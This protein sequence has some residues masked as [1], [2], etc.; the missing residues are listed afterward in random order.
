M[1]TDTKILQTLSAL[2]VSTTILIT[3]LFQPNSLKAE[4]SVDFINN[5]G[6]RLFYFAERPQQL[7]VY[8]NAGEYINFG[9]SHVGISGGFINVYRPDGTLHSTYNNTGTTAGQAIINDNIEE[10]NGP[11]GGGS[12]Q[13]FGYE[14]GIVEVDPGEEGVWTITLEY[15]FYQFTGFDNLLN[16]EAWTREEDQPDNRRVVLSWDITISQNAAAN[17]GGNMLTGRVFTN[18]YQSIV[19]GN[20][21][22][23]SPTYFL[24]T[25]EGLQFQIDYNDVDPWGFQI[26][27]N[28]KG[29]TTGDLDPT[30]ASFELDEVL[31]SADVSSFNNEQFYLY[32]PQARDLE[33]ITNNKVFFNLPDPNMPATAMVTDIA[34]NDT[35]ITWLYTEAP[36][37]EIEV[38]DVS[39]LANDPVNGEGLSDVLDR[40]NGALITYRTNLGGNV[41]L[42]IDIDNDGIY[43]N[44]NDRIINE[45]AIDGQNQILWD[46]L[47]QNGLALPQQFNRELSYRL[48]VNA[49]ELHLTLSDIE[50]DNGG[51]TLTRLNGNAPNDQFLYDH[52]R[53]GEAVSGNG[54]TPELT[55]E[56]FTFS[57][58]FGD[59]KILDYWT[60]VASVSTI[61]SLLLDVVD[62]VSI[63]P[64]DS[65][66]D[67]IRDDNDID[68]DNDGILDQFEICA[69]L[70]GGQCFPVGLNP[71]FDEDFDGVPNYLDA[72][73]P[74]FDLGCID[75]NA[76]GICDQILFAFDI[77]QDGVPNHLDLDADND[78]I[79]DILE[80]NHNFQD[81]DGNGTIDAAG[82][83]FGLNGL[84]NPLG[85]DDDD[86]TAD[87]NYEINDADNDT[88]PDVYDLD[89][90]NDGI[91]DVAEANFGSFDTDE[92]GML[93]EGENGITVNAN[94]L[95]SLVDLNVNGNQIILPLDNDADQIFNFRDRD[96]DNDGLT[97]AI[98]GRNLDG[99]ADGIIG[100]GIITVNDLGVPISGLGA[101]FT[102]RSIIA[103][104]DGDAIEDYRDLDSDNDGIFDVAEALLTDSDNDGFLFAGASSVDE[105][106]MQI[107]PGTNSANY[108][109]FAPDGDGDSVANYLD[110]DSDNDGIHDVTEA[111][112]ED[113]EGD[114][115]IGLISTVDV[116]GLG[117]VINV[118]NTMTSSFPANNDADNFPDY[119]DLDADNDGINDVVE[120][121]N[122]DQDNDG[123]IDF[124]VNEFGQFVNAG[125]ILTTSFPKDNDND[126]VP[127]FHDLDSD[128]DGLNDVLE[129]G[130]Q[131]PDN[132]GIV[133]T[134]N[135]ATNSD[136]QVVGQN[137]TIDTTSFPLDTDNDGIFDYEDLDADND[138]IFDANEANLSDE[139][140]DGILGV[141]QVEVDENG[142][143]ILTSGNGNTSNPVDT[144]GDGI[145]DFRDIDS[146][147]DQI[148][149]ETECPTGAPCPDFDQS[150]IADFIEFNSITCPIPLVTPTVAHD[151]NICSTDMLS[152]TVNEANI[153]EAAYPGV[154]I[155]YI[156]TNA[157]GI[158]I[159][160]TNNPNYNINGDDPL[161]ILPIMVRVMIDAD[162]E[163]S[164]SN[165]IEVNITPT[166]EAIAT[167]EFDNICVGG[168]VQLLAQEV[169]GASYQWFFN[170]FPF[171]TNQNPILN[172]LNQ[173]TNFGLEVTLN[174]CTSDMGNVF[175]V[176]DEPA[177]IEAQIGTGEYCTGEDVIFTAINNNTDL[178]GN[179]TYTLTGPDGLM[180]EVIAPANGTFEYTLPSVDF[181]NE[182]VYSIIV[183]NGSGCTSNVET[184]DVAIMEGVEQPDIIV[185]DVSVCSG[186]DIMMSTQ[187]FTGPNVM[188]VWSLN[189]QPLDTTTTPNFM[190][191]NAT[192]LDEG[193]YQVQVSS[194]I[195]GT[196]TSAPVAVSLT[197]TSILPEIE[198]NLSGNTACTGQTVNLRVNNPTPET[199]YTWYDPSGSLIATDVLDIDIINIQ[200]ANQGT[201]TVEAN[202]NG[203]AIRTSE[204]ELSVSEGLT[205]PDFDIN[206]L[207]SCAGQDVSIAINNFTNSANTTYTWFTSNDVFF[208]QTTTPVLIFPDANTSI[209]GGYYVVAEQGGCTSSASEIFNVNLVEPPSEMA[210]AGQDTGFC[211]STV[212]NLSATNPTQGTGMWIGT[213]GT[214]V[215]PSNPNTQVDN[216]PLGDNIFTWAL[217]TNECTNYSMD[218]V[219]ISVGDVPNETA[220]IFNTESSFCFSDASDLILT[221]D[222][223]VQSNGQWVM[224]SGPSNVTFTDENLSFTSVSGLVPGTYEVMWQLNTASCGVFS[225][226]NYA[227]TIDELPSDIANAGPDQSFCQGAEVTTFAVAPSVG[228]GAWSSNTGA[229]FSNINDPNATVSGLALGVNVLT[230]TLS[231]G[232]C[233]AYDVDEVV[234]EVSISPN[235]E[236]SVTNN[237]IQICEGDVLNLEAVTPN[238]SNGTWT[239]ISGPQTNIVNPNASITNINYN[240]PGT[241][242]FAWQLS[243]LDCGTFSS[244]NVEVIIDAIPNELANAGVDQTTCGTTIS[245]FAEEVQ[246][247]QGFWTS[248]AGNIL[249]PTNPF[250]VVENLV[251]GTH[252]FTWTLSNGVCE[253]FS[254]DQ[255]LI[256]IDNVPNETAQ[257]VDAVI[258]VCSDNNGGIV[259]LNAISPTLST[260][261]WTQIDGPSTV[262]ILDATNENASATGF[263]MGQYNFA[264]TLSSGFCINFSSA[265]LTINVDEVPTGQIANAGADQNI[266]SSSTTNLSASMPTVGSG[267]WTIFNTNGASVV[268]VTDP[269]S[270][271]ILVEGENIFVWS[272]SNGGCQNYQQDTVSVF[273]SLPEDE[274]VV[275]TEDINICETDI[276]SITLNASQV[277]TATGVWTQSTGPTTVTINNPTSTEA[278]LTDLSPGT[279]TFQWTLSDG[280]CENYDS[281]QITVVIS[282][283][284]EEMA[285]IA[286]DEIEICG[287][288]QTTLTAGTP[289]ESTGAWSTN[290]SGTISSINSESTLVSNLQDGANVFTWTLSSGNCVDFSTASITVFV[291]EGVSAVSDTYS[292]EG[293]NT[294]TSENVLDNEIFNGNTDWTLALV[295]D[296]PEVTL[297]NDGSFTFIPVSGFSGIYTFEYEICDQSC[298]VCERAIV[299]ID[300]TPEPVLECNVPNVLTPN[301]DNKNDALI[302]DCANQFE[303]NIIQIFNRWGDKVHEK[304]T[305]QNDWRGTFEGDD[306]PAG[307]YFY[308]FKKDQDD[309]EAITGYITIIR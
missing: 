305:Y 139:D 62:D 86:L 188:Y 300:V 99:D 112:N 78:G 230:W 61:S 249:D 267:R 115:V 151:N 59:L 124:T 291:E 193:N 298:G 164:P 161:L 236:A 275:V 222:N 106:G 34:R 243:T 299:N 26:N 160:T 7:K 285:N 278:N 46:G 308:I 16:N 20:G 192:T 57:N 31:R 21:V 39:L 123:Q 269:N 162:C 142:R 217:S 19:N 27:S 88:H 68:N 266:C 66:G 47:D 9:A 224:V 263:I 253:N 163:S 119:L 282:S 129:G 283:I 144:D 294:L 252:T 117:V 72:D 73:D 4:G 235:E 215:D 289:I 40:S 303:N 179:I 98:E 270:E 239:Q 307:T 213:N 296:S 65:D 2:I 89:S 107:A 120:G 14:P 50:N 293:G 264:W 229:S 114:G 134:G 3:L 173:S 132:D 256:T 248:T 104:H 149:D 76:D 304:V 43:G 11:T 110:R 273:L 152:L 238:N 170:S 148:N 140:Y 145:P 204:E 81:T 23:T 174:G 49:G 1:N 221:A 240:T 56:P 199:V 186:D 265:N 177:I 211:E 166:P 33:D 232:A 247:G 67:G 172:A 242:N 94:G 279:Y 157:D 69:N 30:Y 214:I 233:Q 169:P 176:A 212:V 244:A 250:T 5:N 272:L 209:N 70:E 118:P 292:V 63:I 246:T 125:Q 237:S 105:F 101:P 92:N 97:D 182:G 146:D 42:I 196:S 175:I 17:D 130:S 185:S 113:P 184:F 274:A 271:V 150:G 286:Q 108:I 48:V 190:V 102:V 55:S 195:C 227:F 29:I 226:D 77:D 288:N 90:D 194:G 262:N 82:T 135:P 109:P 254:N 79:T 36:E 95:I 18:E 171:S 287:T 210:S 197:D 216:L 136:G 218:T 80:A 41:Q 103:D 22:T 28:N 116:N 37:F 6:Y 306:L 158:D 54:T 259:N 167:S 284:P 147:N 138:G 131:D 258:D 178:Q 93:V 276:S 128:N 38:L 200:L 191:A 203:C 45:T 183:D 64:N 290:G 91:Y 8:A 12:T 15:G 75:Q 44:N 281:D 143:V 245:L 181:V 260:G 255:V 154:D 205:M 189:G 74:A 207:T 100:E 133:G 223:P 87:V 180:V 32:E 165:P 251:P 52:S 280:L 168:T 198:S 153:Y 58:N 141:G 268:D 25:N 159:M 137:G 220:T 208:A 201:Y 111:G 13:G 85:T 35:H 234:I 295:S 121:G 60:Y 297:N 231:N 96:S 309:N 84:Y 51:V 126:G 261:V 187:V 24:L 225:T 257:V 277:T 122:V 71:D 202:I 10:L 156:W 83:E 301:N 127:N 53:L 206:T 219:V 302:I 241:Y 228:T 155:M